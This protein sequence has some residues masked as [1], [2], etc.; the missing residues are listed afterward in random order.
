MTEF[1]VYLS[2]EP[3]TPVTEDLLVTISEQLEEATK[4]T[5]VVVGAKFVDGIIDV[6]CNISAKNARSAANDTIEQ[7]WSVARAT[8][9]QVVELAAQPYVDPD[10][11]ELVT[12]AEIARRLGLSRAR[13]QQ[14]VEVPGFPLVRQHTGPRA[15]LYRWGDVRAWN[16]QRKEK[17]TAAA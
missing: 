2:I 1:C 5:G 13:V 11:L 15:A 16:K 6:T 8:R 9:G 4:L 17:L 10:D 14:L 7:V 12:K 3:T